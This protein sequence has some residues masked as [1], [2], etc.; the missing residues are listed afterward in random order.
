MPKSVLLVE[1]DIP[2]AH[3]LSR[4]LEER[5]FTVRTTSDGKEGFDLARSLHPDCVVLCV[6]LPGLSGYA[7]CNRLKKDEELH[8]IPLVITSAEATPETFEQHRKLKTHADDYLHKPFAPADLV[9][10]VAALAGLPEATPP[11]GEELDEEIVVV[12]DDLKVLD[13]AFDSIIRP[14]DDSVDLPPGDEQPLRLVPEGD[15]SHLSPLDR[16]MEAALAS[17]AEEA[18]RVP[19]PPPVDEG[20]EG[21]Q[22]VL[23]EDELLPPLEPRTATP[24]RPPPL[25][26]AMAPGDAE[27]LAAARAE[28]TRLRAES[29]TLRSELAA[30]RSTVDR[31]RAAVEAARAEAE[32]IRAESEGRAAT[33]SRR[34]RELEDQAS[35]SEQ[36]AARA[37]Q[38]LRADEKLREKTR[39]A[40]ALVLQILEER[41]PGDPG[42]APPSAP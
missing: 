5:G 37:L 32:A 39:K 18:A 8:A 16:D 27:E 30:I 6:E 28:A 19:A 2:L 20:A 12:E 26:A 1:S 15:E 4:A 34:A 38:R 3:E 9:E 40:L 13:D 21:P 41:P 36:R 29:E 35:A 17:L 24:P 23:E 42:S 22:I 31:L 33:L 11:E 10:R 14:G 25:A 7:W